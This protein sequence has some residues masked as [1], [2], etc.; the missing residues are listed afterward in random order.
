MEISQDFGKTL[1]VTTLKA[2]LKKLNSSIQFDPGGRLGIY[3]PRQDEWQGVYLNDKHITSMD[4]GPVV[5]E[6]NV[7]ELKKNA[8]SGQFERT[9]ILRIG[10]RFTMEKMVRKGVVTWPDLCKM[11]DVDYKRFNGHISE[12][13][14]A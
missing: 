14:V 10:W 5:P 8:L 1:D 9:K 13:E 4:R 2:G 7:W 12:L 11:F 6:Y 3:H